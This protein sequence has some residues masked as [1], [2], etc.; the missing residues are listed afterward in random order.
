MLVRIKLNILKCLREVKICNIQF[1]EDVFLAI[2]V[3]RQVNLSKKSQWKA[4]RPSDEIVKTV[5][6]LTN[7]N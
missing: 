7:E 1:A 5:C 3:A 4:H 2:H 6:F